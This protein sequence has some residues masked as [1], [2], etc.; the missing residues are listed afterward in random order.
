MDNTQRF[1]GRVEEY[2]RYRMRYP[3]EHVLGVIRDWCGLVPGWRIADV[4]AGTG[5]LAEVFLQN[6][7]SVVAVEPNEEMRS[8]CEGLK[9]RFSELQVVDATAEA[10]G[11]EDSSFDMVVAGRAF[12][13]FD[14]PRALREFR[15]ILRP[16]GWI[17]LVAVGRSK[18]ESEQGRAYEQLL[19][20]HGTDYEYVREGFRVHDRLDELFGSAQVRNVEL[21]SEVRLSLEEFVGQAMSSSFAPLPGHPKYE[22]M[23]AALREFFEG[24]GENGLLAMQMSC[25][26]NCVSMSAVELP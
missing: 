7:N 2:Q 21:R 11:L 24:Y 16:D 26:I 8:G 1:T 12:H 25:W 9:E 20:Q 10:T 14:A 17:G 23:Q 13:W 22:G 3:D 19:V 18:A 5:M 4:G 15:R 6:G